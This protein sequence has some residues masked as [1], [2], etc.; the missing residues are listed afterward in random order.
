MRILEKSCKIA[1]ASGVRPQTSTLLLSPTASAF[2]ECVSSIERTLLLRKITE[3]THPNCF[4]FIFSA[5]SYLFFT[6]NSAVFVGGAVEIHFAP[7]AWYT[8]KGLQ[9]PIQ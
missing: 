5:L 4:G 8:Q 7:G 1:A 2:V 3:V 9:A 6:S